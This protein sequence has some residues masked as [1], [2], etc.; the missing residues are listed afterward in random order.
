MR[1]AVQIPVK[2][3]ST[4]VPNKNFRELCGKPLSFW[5]LDEL[6]RHCPEEWDIYI[7]SENEENFD[8]FS[9]YSERVCFHKRHQWFASDEA[10]GNHLITQF[11]MRRPDYDI[12]VQAY[13]TA[14]T[15]SGKTVRESI[16]GFIDKVE[17]YD[18]M[19]LAIKECGWVWYDKFAINYKPNIPNGLPRSQDATYFK[20]TTGLYATTKENVFKNACR[21]GAKPLI[22]E[23]ERE[24]A[25]DIDT[26]Q[27]FLEAERILNRRAK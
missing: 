19:F 2:S 21:V 20:E 3:R 10:N 7:D 12:Y 25:M 27:D 26:Q 22:Y 14:V 8:F 13:V 6:I 17:E 1:V 15:L 4:R 11:A 23:I 18:S 9:K 24:E 5:L 16:E